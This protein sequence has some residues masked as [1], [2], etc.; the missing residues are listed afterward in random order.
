LERVEVEGIASAA[1]P[2]VT[3]EGPRRGS[4]KRGAAGSDSPAVHH[5]EQQPAV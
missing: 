3:I 2:L 1:Q 4:A 5:S